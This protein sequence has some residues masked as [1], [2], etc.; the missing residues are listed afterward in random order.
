MINEKV[1]TK[2][3]FIKEKDLRLVAMYFEQFLEDG[4]D[5]ISNITMKFASL[6][7]IKDECEVS[8]L[9]RN[10]R[11][12]HLSDC[13]WDSPCSVRFII[14]DLSADGMERCNFEIRE[15]EG[16]FCFYCEKID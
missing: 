2:L 3:Q 7:N 16:L 4:T 10:C 11:L 1:T 14:E 8:L 15:C 12:F 5:Y 9:F 6:P 13:I